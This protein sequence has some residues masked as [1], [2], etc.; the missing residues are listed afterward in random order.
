MP[1]L[2]EITKD[3]EQIKP[4]QAP[5][6]PPVETR[7]DEYA[8]APTLQESPKVEELEE[9]LENP[10]EET[11]VPETKEEQTPVEDQETS[12]KPEASKDGTGTDEKNK[13]LYAR[14]K[15]AEAKIKEFESTE[16]KEEAPQQTVEE[17]ADVV[18]IFQGLDKK[19]RSRLIQEKKMT[20]K[21]YEEVLSSDDYSL[22]Q[23]A[24]K[25]KMEKD[26]ALAPSTRQ[27]SQPLNAREFGSKWKSGSLKK[28]DWAA[29]SDKDKESALVGMGLVKDYRPP[30]PLRPREQ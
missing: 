24:Y 26:K 11:T 3:T 10:V 9:T 15:K 12:P 25:K 19:E 17:L 7:P 23:T 4:D 22:W 27:S 13:R 14:L 5:A 8:E 2:V 30:A 29:M 18:N 28:D 21:S 16:P 1:R 20:G 6:P